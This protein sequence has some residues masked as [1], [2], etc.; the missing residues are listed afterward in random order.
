MCVVCLQPSSFP[1][2]VFWVINGHRIVVTLRPTSVFSSFWVWNFL[3]IFR[4]HN[5]YSGVGKNMSSNGVR[6]F[7]RIEC[8]VYWCLRPG[9]LPP[10]PL[11]RVWAETEFKTRGG[12]SIAVLST[13]CPSIPSITIRHALGYAMQYT[14]GMEAACLPSDTC[15]ILVYP[16][17]LRCTNF[18]P[19]LP[20]PVHCPSLRTLPWVIVLADSLP[21]SRQPHP[22]SLPHQFQKNT[23]SRPCR[24]QCAEGYPRTRNLE[25][26][27]LLPRLVVCS[28][29]ISDKRAQVSAA[30]LDIGTLN[31]SELGSQ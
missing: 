3:Q 23:N 4:H 5:I 6:G 17:T 13:C 12:Q 14:C 27:S 1:R 26:Q 24:G 31:N 9:R 15:R 16:F 2:V 21:S 18:L 29:Q 11:P 19:E 8:S 25:K 10:P 7:R 30:P 22:N 20:L 28:I